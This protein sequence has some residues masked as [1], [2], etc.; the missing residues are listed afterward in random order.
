MRG[1]AMSYSVN[2][3]GIDYSKHDLFLI[4]LLVELHLSLYMVLSLSTYPVPLLCA[5]GDARTWMT[6]EG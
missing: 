5:T 1:P 2:N 6:A 4:A 3:G